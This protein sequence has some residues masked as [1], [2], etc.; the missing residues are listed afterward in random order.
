M[1]DHSAGSATLASEELVEERRSTGPLPSLQVL[2][3]SVLI[4]LVDQLTKLWVR[5][6][7]YVG[8]SIP[9]IDSWLRLTFTENPGMAF[10]IQLG[11]TPVV[12]AFA[13]LATGLIVAYL[14]NL[15]RGPLPYRLSI[16]VVLGGA[17]GNIIDRVFYGKLFSYGTYFNGQ[18]VD[19]IHVNLW[20][21]TVAEWVPVLGGNTL[22]LFP[23]W[24]VADM[25]I[26]LGVV[27]MLL[28]QHTLHRD[29]GAHGSDHPGADGHPER[30]SASDGS[31]QSDEGRG[32]L[33]SNSARGGSAPST[34]G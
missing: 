23:I 32:A 1:R 21:G 28:V 9:V 12:T 31:Q 22:A 14:W 17:V 33:R 24:N 29:A 11:S 4:V 5:S 19:F 7:M 13:M 15:R 16:A 3:I 27:G 20:R 25:A 8:E 6:S 30:S 2:W 26:V 18:V 34:S 10:G